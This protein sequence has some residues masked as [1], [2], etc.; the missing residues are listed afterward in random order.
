M[1]RK[2][3]IL[4]WE[5]KACLE[6]TPMAVKA[7]AEKIG[8]DYHTIYCELADLEQ[9]GKVT[10]VKHDDEVMFLWTG[11]VPKFEYE[12]STN[13]VEIDKIQC[14]FIGTPSDKRQ[15]KFPMFV[16][17]AIKQKI[18]SINKFDLMLEVK[19]IKADGVWYRIQPKGV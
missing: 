1:K 4:Y 15:I 13:V 18:G 17:K 11:K 9:L 12:L 8:V 10:K 16:F 6:E 3:Q 14:Q 5:I 2:S 19:A 7:I